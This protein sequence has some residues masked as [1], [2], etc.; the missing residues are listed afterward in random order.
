MNLL[1]KFLTLTLSVLVLIA[2]ATKAPELPPDYVSVHTKQ[3]L[4][5][6]DFDPATAELTCAEINQELGELNSE[7]ATQSHEITQKRGSNQTIGYIG[8][9]FFLPLMLATDSSV[10]AKEKITNIN[11]AKDKLYKLKAFKKCP[12]DDK[13]TN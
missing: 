12:S 3:R 13:R 6:D 10:Q 5:V 1:N 11:I 4:S 8:G 2:C 9:M 7:R